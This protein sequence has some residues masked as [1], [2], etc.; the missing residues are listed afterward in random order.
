MDIK[1]KFFEDSFI[2]AIGAGIYEI[3]IQK[4]IHEELL[5]VGESVFV[6]V[7]CAT[8]LHEIFKGRGYLGFTK[9]MINEGGFTLVFRLNSVET[10]TV[11]RKEMEKLI[12]KEKN[13]KMQSGI[14]DRVKSIEK[15]IEEMTNIL[16]DQAEVL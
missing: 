1:V 6:L 13:P 3:Y 16:N 7:R 12:V 2:D 5:Y 9:E 8:H 11:S 14:S 10:D 15:M 4:G